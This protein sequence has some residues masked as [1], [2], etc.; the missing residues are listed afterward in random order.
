MILSVLATA[1]LSRCTCQMARCD[2]ELWGEHHEGRDA[3]HDYY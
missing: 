2:D 3:I 1:M